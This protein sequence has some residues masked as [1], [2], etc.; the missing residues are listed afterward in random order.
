MKCFRSTLSSKLNLKSDYPKY[1]WRK[2]SMPLWKEFDRQVSL[3][4]CFFLKK[5]SQNLLYLLTCI[6]ILLLLSN[7]ELRN[8]VALGNMCFPVISGPRRRKTLR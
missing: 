1:L 6:P 3:S 7:E 2:C 4:K 8:Y 5:N